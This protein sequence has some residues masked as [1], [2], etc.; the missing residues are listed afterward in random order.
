MRDRIINTLALFGASLIFVAVLGSFSFK[1]RI[2]AGGIGAALL[3]NAYAL[4]GK[5]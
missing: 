3:L 5:K 2:I 1:T 4:T